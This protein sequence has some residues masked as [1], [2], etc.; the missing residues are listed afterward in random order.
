M[1][2]ISIS[3]TTAVQDLLLLLHEDW[4]PEKRQDAIKRMLMDMVDRMDSM[5][6]GE[7]WQ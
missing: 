5:E 3:M 4:M 1:Q 6:H 7:G 2:Q